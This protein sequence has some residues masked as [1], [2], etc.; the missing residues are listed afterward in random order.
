MKFNLRRVV[1]IILQVPLV[2]V[3]I[4]SF[5]ISFYLGAINTKLGQQY[6]I[7]YGA[8]VISG[9]IIILYF[10]GVFLAFKRDS[11]KKSK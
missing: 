8:A 3:V 1:G 9:I 2:L 5:L 10:V 11:D 7:T 6:G 4:A